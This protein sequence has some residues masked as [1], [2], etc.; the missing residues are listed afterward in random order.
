MEILYMV[1]FKKKTV[2]SFSGLGLRTFTPLAVFRLCL[3]SLEYKPNYTVD[4]AFS[5]GF[6]EK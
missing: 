4:P 6:F 5:S 2:K 3:W 1:L